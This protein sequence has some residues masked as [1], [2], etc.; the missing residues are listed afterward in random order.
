[1]RQADKDLITGIVLLVFNIFIYTQIAHIRWGHARF[2]YSAI[3]M[4]MS[5]NVLFT[6]LTVAL[7]AKSIVKGGRFRFGEWG[8]TLKTNI[9]T[10]EF[11]VVFTFTLIIFLLV[12]VAVPAVGFWISGSIFMLGVLLVCVKSFRPLFS[13]IFTVATMGILYGIFVRIF[14]VPIR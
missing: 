1:M 13:I 4:P 9:S 8:S 2:V 12:F 6:I 5:A 10:R 7:I 14:M 11:R 3:L